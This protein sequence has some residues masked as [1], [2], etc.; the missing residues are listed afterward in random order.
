MNRGGRFVICMKIREK[1]GG[2][3]VIGYVLVD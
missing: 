3:L 2:S 1:G